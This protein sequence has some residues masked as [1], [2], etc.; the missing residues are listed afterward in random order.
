MSNMLTHNKLDGFFTE[1]LINNKPDWDME[2]VRTAALICSNALLLNAGYPKDDGSTA[3]KL[4]VEFTNGSL[5]QL[6]ELGDFFD[7]RNDDPYKVIEMAIGLLESIKQ[8]NSGKP[9]AE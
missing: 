5:Q 2:T 7:V 3:E 9:K 1:A 4:V 8:R 6:R